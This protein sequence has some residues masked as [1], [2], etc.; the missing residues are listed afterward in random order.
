MNAEF[1]PRRDECEAY[2]ARLRH[3]GVPAFARTV[4]GHVH[5]SMG[6]K[7]WEP[8]ISWPDEANHTLALANSNALTFAAA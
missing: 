1:D 3:A 6:I 2:V 7:G 8:A 5:G 4:K